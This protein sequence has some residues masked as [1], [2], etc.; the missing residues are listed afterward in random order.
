MSS[1]SNLASAVS[2]LSGSRCVGRVSEVVGLRLTVVGLERILGVGA[3]CRVHRSGDSVIGEVI[4]VDK[5]GSHL[6]PFGDWGGVGP[7][8]EVECLPGVGTLRPGPEWVGR[9]IN[10]LGQPI[11]SLGP[12]AQGTSERPLHAEAP[13]PFHRRAVGARIETGIKALDVFAPLCRGQRM[14]IFAGSGVGKSTLM[15]MLT[16][17]AETDVV[18]VALVGERGREVRDFVENA[19]GEEGMRRAVLVVA[20]GDEAPLMRRQAAFTATSVAESFRDQGANVLL[21]V[22]SVTR[23]AHAHREIG[24][25]LGEPPAARGYPPTVFSLLPQ[26]LERAGPGGEGQGNI[27]ALYTVLMDG[28]DPND[29]IVDAVRGTLDGHIHLSRRVAERGRFPAIDVEKSLSRMLPHCH[30]DQEN[31]IMLQM[32]RALSRYGEM[33]DLVRLGVYK[34]GTNALVDQSIKIAEKAEEAL[35]QGTHSRVS[36]LEAFSEF[37]EILKDNTLS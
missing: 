13:S 3:R 10:A 37:S 8:A 23:F 31:E 36:T 35:R 18:V 29:P 16:R 34:A 26:L 9:V 19:L 2:E 1:I 15:S 20:T 7:G 17:Q 6:L 33:E 28:D 25:S 22:D 5:R 32:R 14:G 11:D 24:L 27:T 12:L 4:G 30:S 21:M